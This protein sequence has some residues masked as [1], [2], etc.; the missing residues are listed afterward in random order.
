DQFGYYPPNNVMSMSAAGTNVDSAIN[1][2]LYELTGVFV[3]NTA[4]LFRSASGQVQWTQGAVMGV[5]RRD[6]FVN[7]V[8]A[9]QAKSTKS[10]LPGLKASQVRTVTVGAQPVQLLAVPVDYPNSYAGPRP[11]MVPK[12]VNPWRY[13]STNPTNNPNGFDLWAEVPIGKEIRII[14][15]WKE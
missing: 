5:F 8:E 3:D 6:G 7:A 4:R 14:G 10:F 12:Q 1:P 9:K 13:V 2:I 11:A 15:N